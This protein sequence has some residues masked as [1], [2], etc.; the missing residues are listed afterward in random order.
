ME[1]NPYA[2]TSIPSALNDFILLEGSCSVAYKYVNNFCYS[3]VHFGDNTIEDEVFT[4]L[5]SSTSSRLSSFKFGIVI[6]SSLKMFLKCKKCKKC[7]K[8][9]KC[10]KNRKF[11]E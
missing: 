10:L 3:F 2:I 7:K 5:E 1:L 6:A 4:F 11:K 9:K 8:S